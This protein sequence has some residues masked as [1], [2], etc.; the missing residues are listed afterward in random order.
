MLSVSTS[1]VE[2]TGQASDVVE[3]IMTIQHAAGS[4]A[5]AMDVVLTDALPA[6]LT[7]SSGL[8]NSA[9]TVPA[10]LVEASDVINATFSS[11]GT[12]ETSEIRFFAT[13]DPDVEVGQVITNPANVTWTSLPGDVTTAQSTNSLSTERTGQ[14]SD[15][16]STAN[17][18]ATTA[19][20]SITIIDP[21]AAK[22]FV[23]SNQGHTSGQ[24]FAIGEIGTYEIALTLPQGVTP[25]AQVVDTPDAGL[26]IVDVVSITPSAGV[27]TDVVGG[28]AAV[29]SA[30]TIPADGSSLTLD[31]GD[32]TNADANSG[33]TETVV[34]RYR[35]VV[36]NTTTNDRSDVIDNQAVFSWNVSDT[37]NL[38]GPDLTIVEPELSVTV[39]DSVPA[40]ADAG[41]TVTFTVTI[42]HTGA[43]DA[44][45]FNVDL[46]NAIDSVTSNHLDYAPGTLNIVNA[47]GA[48]FNTSADTGGDLTA[49]WS[50]FPQGATA[51]I[52][53]D[54][55]VLLS[56]PAS[57]ALVNDADIQWTSLP[58]DVSSAQSSNTLSVERT[59]DTTDVGTTAN[60]HA[61]NDSGQ[62][63]TSAPASS[64]TIVT[65]DY[66]G[67]TAAEFDP[68]LDDVIVGEVVT[69]SV[70]AVLP[71]GSN[72]LVI[73][74]QLPTG[75]GI[76]ELMSASVQSVGSQLTV[77]TPTI[78][79]SDSD[80]DTIDD[81]AVFDFGT[82]VNT[83]D[84]VANASDEIEVR[85]VAR[86]SDVIGNANSLVLT[87][88]S[89]VDLSGSLSVST[90]DVEVVEPVLE[91]V[92]DANVTTGPPGTTV[93][94]TV[95]ISHTAASTAD[96]FDLAIADL[97]S[98]SNLT[99]VSGTVVTDRGTITS[100]NGATDSTVAL[101]L[102]SLAQA[103]TVTITFDAVTNPSIGG[104]VAIVN[105]STLGYDNFSGLGGRA[106]SDSD[107][108]TFTTAPPE[109]N[110]AITKS[111]SVDPAVT[112]S[113]LEYTLLVTNNG[114]STANNVMLTDNLPAGLTGISASSSQGSVG[115]AGLVV[116]GNLGTLL[117]GASATVTIDV[118]TPATDGVITNNA[119]VSADEIET[120]GSDNIVAEP[121]T[122]VSTSSIAG[123]S[124]VDTD[125][126]G[127]ADVGE[128]LLPGVL[129]TLTGVNDLGATISQT[130]TTDANGDYLFSMLRPGTYQV[131]Q[132]QPTLFVDNGDFA[133]TGGG[134]VV[135]DQVE[136]TIPGGVDVTGYNFTEL[137]LLPGT[138]GKRRLLNSTLQSGSS[139]AS[140]VFFSTL[141]ASG[142]GDLDSD[143]DTD[144]DDFLLFQD[145][146]GEA[147]VF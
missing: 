15:P 66:V 139:L 128:I 28:F 89:T 7:F 103:E 98:D 50:V 81:R 140:D 142:N 58:G 61:G 126:D 40:T 77:G 137:G 3:I 60:D 51:T 73:T 90:A 48:V 123:T 147:W 74:D 107:D 37:Q 83:P 105:T 144:N 146:L 67:T 19:S 108:E 132:T 96:A 135:N 91:I 121:T 39:S 84:G 75:P 76:L 55:V 124:W 92:K 134:S 80:I 10:T 119:N 109:I 6:G 79:I 43:S 62:V 68:T 87:N 104:S 112:S 95:G 113:A 57:T 110:L 99:L 16:G 70:I 53:F 22:T 64:K 46:Q 118:T 13:I 100:G 129:V 114:P 101:T 2:A 102:S 9:G 133:G 18:H 115:V 11:L 20:D 41:D 69:Y 26:A 49:N 86:V 25:N 143:L 30:A 42:A 14:T 127:V 44:D 85:I 54:A 8:S 72:T 1:I 125:S 131:T 116:S 88:T 47:G 94:Y 136:L 82:V 117:P 120:D 34:I 71:E 32:L 5:T 23:S 45:A 59:G 145:R 27:T 17:D 12:T 52:T 33:T 65:T 97:L 29:Q 31:F 138:F 21:S 106:D 24:N 63:T 93:S 38:D 56:A 78:T 35:A 122:I 111:D 4:D 36:L 130:T 141:G